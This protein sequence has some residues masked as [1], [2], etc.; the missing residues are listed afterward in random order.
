LYVSIQLTGPQLNTKFRSDINGLRAI[1]VALV[2]LF[3]LDVPPFKGGF[4][5]VDVFFVISGFLM[6]QIIKDAMNAGTFNLGVFY[7]NRIARIVPALLIVT[8]ACLLAGYFILLPAEFLNLA[9]EAVSASL[10][11][12]NFRFIESQGYFSTNT[13]HSWL[14]HCWSLA[15]EFQFYV[16]FPLILWIAKKLHGRMGI[17]TA[18]VAI[19]VVS[20]AFSL[21]QTK[22]NPVF[23]F[24][25]LP[26]RAWEFC[27]GGLVLYMP[28]LAQRYR[29]VC[30]LLGVVVI[31]AASVIYDSQ[32][33]YPA[34][35]PI[36]P[37]LGAAC[38]LAA[39][40]NLFL[41]KNTVSQ[42][43]G[44]ISYSVYLWHWPLIAVVHYFDYSIGYVEKTLLIIATFGFAF[45]SHRF[46][47]TPFRTIFR[48][49]SVTKTLPFAFTVLCLSIFSYAV[50]SSNGWASRLPEKIVG[51]TSRAAHGNEYRDGTCFLSPNQKFTDFDGKCLQ[52]DSSSKKPTL[53]IWGDSHAAHLYPGIER[54]PWSKNYNVVQLTA[55]A[56][57]PLPIE[58]YPERI[59]CPLIQKLSRN[60][61][62]SSKPDVLILAGSWGLD[63]GEEVA[64]LV[65]SLKND[66]VKRVIVV[67]RVPIWPYPASKILFRDN[68][69]TGNLHK[70]KSR[71]MDAQKYTVSD[72]KLRDATTLAGASYASI[73]E[74]LCD[75]AYCMTLIPNWPSD[76]LF[77]FDSEH[78]TA[79]GSEWI[80][81]N[82]IGPVLGEGIPQP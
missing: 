52:P 26:S 9:R 10:F 16:L 41:L 43:I 22:S 7:I 72:Q 27:V 38:I 61:F 5:G 33:T 77:Q 29:N 13:A 49:V 81:T 45:L 80:A 56:C 37:V 39:N 20:A 30:S 54:Q 51:V 71:L 24:Y 42:M 4:V 34:L 79:D 82:V 17:P 53:A 64:T 66:G 63:S 75:E 15:V 18:L 70:N 55:S 28:S 19:I 47:E 57:S 32:L 46:I 3:H 58:K 12:I 14:L 73:R 68:L 60:F 78:L 6:T 67:G 31:V 35:W 2:V 8:A 69:F 65:K 74:S 50:I 76:A 1:A 44:T 62:A 21:V 23:A 36:F 11:L 48:P 59:N 25:L 40:S